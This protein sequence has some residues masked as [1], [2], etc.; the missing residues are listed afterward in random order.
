MGILAWRLK[1]IG[2][3]ADVHGDGGRRSR[4][5]MGASHA[6]VLHLLLHNLL[7]RQL[8][9]C[10]VRW[11]HAVVQGNVRAFCGAVHHC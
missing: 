7:G 4:A 11:V 8:L 3:V 1:R 6:R 5:A 9:Q 2:M 10:R